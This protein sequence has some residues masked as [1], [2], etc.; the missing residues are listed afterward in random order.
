MNGTSSRRVVE[1]LTPRSTPAVL[2]WRAHTT[3][4][5][6]THNNRRCFE[7]FTTAQSC[8]PRLTQLA[9]HPLHLHP[10]QTTTTTGAVSTRHALPGGLAYWLVR[11]AALERNAAIDQSDVTVVTSVLTSSAA[12]H[13]HRERYILPS[14]RRVPDPSIDTSGSPLARTHNTTQASTQQ[15]P[16]LR[17]VHYPVLRASFLF[18]LRARKATNKPPGC[19]APAPRETCRPPKANSD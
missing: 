9:H 7:R 15:P 13:Q 12:L 8:A 4:N 11:L 18:A 5:T 3:H 2:P 6:S 14:R 19:V 1:F 16:V 17:A 10:S